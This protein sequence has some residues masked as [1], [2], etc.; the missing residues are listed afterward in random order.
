MNLGTII[1]YIIKHLGKLAVLLLAVTSLSFVLIRFSPVDPIQMYIGADV[2]TV[3]PEQ[4]LAIEKYW[5]LHQSSIEQFKNWFF[6]LLQGDFGTSLIYRKAVLSVI[7]ERFFASFALMG[8]SWILS[9]VIGFFLGSLAGLYKGSIFDK[10]IKGYCFVL[11]STPA[12][13][14]G[15][16]LM[17]V[18]SVWLNL[19]PI[20]LGVQIPFVLIYLFPN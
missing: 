20:G 3:S 17:I 12:F 9:G 7:G 1:K 4:R 18:F 11:A 16:I 5:G 10:I 6:S 2:M 19:F 13:W 15:I 8:L 14:V